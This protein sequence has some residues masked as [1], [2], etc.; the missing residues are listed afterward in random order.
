MPWRTVALVLVGVCISF[1]T[2]S[3]VAP[4]VPGPGPSL[5]TTIDIPSPP[6]VPANATF[7]F[8][9]ADSGVSSTLSAAIQELDRNTGRVVINGIDTAQPAI[10]FTFT[11]G[12]GSEDEG[13]FPMTHIYVDP[14]RDYEAMVTAH[15]GAGRVN[16]RAVAVRFVTPELHTIAV[17]KEIAVT[18]PTSLV[19]LS[20]RVYAAPTGLSAFGDTSLAS[21]SRAMVEYIL[22]IAAWIQCELANGDVYAPDGVFQQVVLH[23]AASG[24]MYSLWFTSPPSFAAGDYA[25]QG[26][27]Q[28]SSFFHEMGHNVTLNSPAAFCYGGKIDGSANA[29]FSETMAQIFAHATA[30]EIINCADAYGLSAALVD[31]VKQSA[32]DSYRLLKSRYEAYVAEG[33]PFASWNDPSTDVDETLDTFMTIA[34]VFCQRADEAGQGFR[35]PLQRMMRLLQTLDAEMENE[36]SSNFDTPTAES[37]R[38]TLM[39]AAISYGLNQDLRQLFRDLGFPVSDEVYTS[40][41]KRVS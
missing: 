22:S 3:C 19:P 29:I 32:I 9:G 28:Y 23:D 16:Q 33:H 35:V 13:W 6:A 15:Y 30:Y 18:I 17:P 24:G 21:A 5:P 4:A 40:L 12:D 7:S 27:P 34:Y 26:S 20:S 2:L 8:E 37:F 31:A 14:S 38:A 39:V 25:F 11:W 36:F 10:P 1:A 41:L